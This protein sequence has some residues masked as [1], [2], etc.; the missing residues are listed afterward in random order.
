M[1][2]PDIVACVIEYIRTL[3]EKLAGNSVSSPLCMELKRLEYNYISEEL[4]EK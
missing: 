1:L 4:V 2:N 3:I